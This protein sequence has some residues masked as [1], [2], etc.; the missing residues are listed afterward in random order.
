MNNSNYVALSVSNASTKSWEFRRTERAPPVPVETA[1]TSPYS[2]SLIPRMFMHCVLFK[3]T[4]PFK[5]LILTKHP[6]TATEK[7]FVRSTTYIPEMQSSSKRKH[8]RNGTQRS[9]FSDF[10]LRKITEYFAPKGRFI[11]QIEEMF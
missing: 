4:D 11:Q 5:R 1:S 2:T 6:I 10:F 8:T 7:P 9:L 3:K